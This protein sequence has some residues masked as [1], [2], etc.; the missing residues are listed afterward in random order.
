MLVKGTAPRSIL[1]LPLARCVTT[2]INFPSLGVPTC[3]TR[4]GHRCHDACHLV[5]MWTSSQ[6]ALPCFSCPSRTGHC[7]GDPL[8]VIG[9]Q[10]GMTHGG[11]SWHPRVAPRVELDSQ[12]GFTTCPEAC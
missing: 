8:A 10:S 9:E 5:S 11:M 6:D 12:C 4:W 7:S 3:L 1:A 2:Q